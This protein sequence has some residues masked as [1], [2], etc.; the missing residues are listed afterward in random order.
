MVLLLA[1]GLVTFYALARSAEA[2]GDP[3]QTGPSRAG[4]AR[5]QS[6]RPA[7]AD[8]PQIEILGDS[9]VSG[10][11]E[12]GRDA[13]NWTR[14]IGTRF[15]DA[16]KPVEM[17]VMAQPGSGYLTRGA[18]GLNFRETAAVR[19]RPTADVV[20]VF[21]SRNDGRQ[22]DEAM[23]NAAKSLYSVIRDTAPQ[24]EIVVFGPVWVNGK[25]P[26]FITANNAA[27]AQAAAEEGVRYIDTNADRWFTGSGKNLI[28]ADGVHPTDDGHGYIA[29]KIFPVLDETLREPANLD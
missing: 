27:M 7:A 17:N 22:T 1:A 6:V 24:A 9:Y 16:G 23:Y 18:S 3:E 25:A 19:I 2:A 8:V 29:T 10:S 15:H 12:G 14:I 28:G 5:A 21:G 11:D 4:T 13:A 20:V 26:E